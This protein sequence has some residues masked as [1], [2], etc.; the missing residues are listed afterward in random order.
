M[1]Y[2]IFAP[3]SAPRG[4]ELYAQ[5][6]QH[7][8]AL[9]IAG[10]LVTP[11]PGRDVETLVRM[12]VEKR[13]S[14][15]VAVGDPGHVN[16]IA[17]AMEN[18]DAVLGIIPTSSHPDLISLIGTGDWKEAAE[19]LKKRRVHEVPMGCLNETINFLT[20]ASV[21]LGDEIGYLGTQGYN[22]TIIGGQLSVS[23]VA[24]GGKVQLCCKVIEPIEELR[25]VRKLFA[26]TSAIPDPTILFA[27]AMEL[28]TSKNMEVIV[29]GDVVCNTP[30]RFS[31]RPKQLRLVASRAN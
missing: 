2:Y 20:P 21:Q 26:K 23:V 27:P 6:K 17:R 3:S 18:Y 14:T 5:I 4:L 25:G 9:G 15:V 24:D 28:T 13:Y 12:A 31:L 29:A 10:E 8:A 22:A 16:R 30:V 7:L 1:Y 11:S 19:Q